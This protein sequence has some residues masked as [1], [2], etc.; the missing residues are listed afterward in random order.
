[1]YIYKAEA[2]LNRCSR[3]V[4]AWTIKCEISTPTC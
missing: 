3:L 2:T 4:E 1:V